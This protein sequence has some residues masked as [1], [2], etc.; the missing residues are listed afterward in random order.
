MNTSMPLRRRVTLAFLLLGFLLSLTF[1]LA[2]VAITEDYESVVAR[3]ILRGQAEDYSLRLSN[4]LPSQLPQTHRLSGY[5]SNPPSAYAAYPPGVREDPLHDGVHVGVFDVPAGRLYFVINLAD[6]E[7][8]ERHLHAT[9]AAIVLLGTLAS[10]WLGWLLARRSLAPVTTLA[11]AVDRLPLVPVRSDLAADASPDDLGRLAEAIDRYQ[12]RLVDA[13]EQEQAFFADASHEL[14]T[15]VAVVRGAAELLREDAAPVPALTPRLDRLD[16]G[17]ADLAD[18]LEI[19]LRL[20]R[21][22]RSEIEPRDAASWSRSVIED[23]LSRFAP[24]IHVRVE[25]SDVQWRLPGHDAALVLRAVARDI[26]PAGASGTLVANVTPHGIEF[27]TTD[28]RIPDSGR[29]RGPVRSDRGIGAG[30]LGRLAHAHGW[31]V[32]GVVGRAVVRWNEAA[33]TSAS[34]A[35]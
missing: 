25:A 15:P 9:L 35:P 28:A 16:R 34:V 23:A 10:G 17:V 5:L 29:P 30:L 18:L 6:I 8:L 21:G 3:E 14:R 20:A 2:A 4:G 19:L 32:D 33:V 24:N 1:A 13:R 11:A 7:A 27:A 22:Q 26:V 12:S 31:T